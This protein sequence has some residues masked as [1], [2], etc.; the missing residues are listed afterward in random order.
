MMNSLCN[1]ASDR[2]QRRKLHASVSLCLCKSFIQ[3]SSIPSSCLLWFQR[4]NP[5]QTSSESVVN[6]YIDFDT[7]IADKHE[8]FSIARSVGDHAEE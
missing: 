3:S 7:E 1:R 6:L 5:K 2:K 4:S 8:A